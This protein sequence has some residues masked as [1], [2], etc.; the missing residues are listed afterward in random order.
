MATIKP[1]ELRK[2]ERI[3]PS[4]DI[5]DIIERDHRE[6]RWTRLGTVNRFK[7]IFIDDLDLKPIINL[8]KLRKKNPNVLFLGAGQGDDIVTLNHLLSFA[9]LEPNYDVLSV[10]KKLS[11]EARA[12]VRKDLSGNFALENVIADPEKYVELI[13]QIKGKYDLI[14]ASL[15]IGI[16]TNWPDRN[17]FATALMLGPEG[18][19]YITVDSTGINQNPRFGF[20]NIKRFIE[21]AKR[22]YNKKNK[23]NLNFEVTLIPETNTTIVGTYYICIKRTA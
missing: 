23:T 9:K 3:K 4:G 11:R 2:I 22:A 16:Y 8:L 14:M 17:A 20:E 1:R 21:L 15:S 7:E 13:S 5:R 18:E 12:I 19:A 6:S 10:T